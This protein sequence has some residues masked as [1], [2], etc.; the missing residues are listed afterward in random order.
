[1]SANT[2]FVLNL[3]GASLTLGRRTIFTDIQIDRLV[4][5]ASA[6]FADILQ[7]SHHPQEVLDLAMMRWITLSARV[8]EAH[9]LDF[10][11]LHEA[12]P[13]AVILAKFTHFCNTAQVELVQQA[14]HALHR[15]DRPFDPTLSAHPP[16]PLSDAEKKDG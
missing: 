16:Q 6:V 14:I 7:A 5:Q 1:V 12:D 8:I 3:D 2:P 9:Q 4:L 13:P 10:E 11:L 15:L